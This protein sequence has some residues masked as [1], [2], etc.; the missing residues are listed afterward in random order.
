MGDAIRLHLAVGSAQTKFLGRHEFAEEKK[1]LII[2]WKKDQ[3]NARWRKQ[4]AKEVANGVYDGTKYV[5]KKVAG[6]LGTAARWGWNQFSDYMTSTPEVTNHQGSQT[7][8]VHKKPSGTC[9]QC[10]GYNRP[11][12]SITSPSELVLRRRRLIHGV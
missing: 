7:L 11:G 10:Q 9:G 8:C 5:G 1:D 4:K 12:L 6:A 2:N 3:E